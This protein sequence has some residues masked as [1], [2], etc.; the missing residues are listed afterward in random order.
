MAETREEAGAKAKDKPDKRSIDVVASGSTSD[1]PIESKR[2]KYLKSTTAKRIHEEGYYLD[3]EM[4][5]L[6][7]STDL[8]IRAALESVSFALIT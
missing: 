3:G 4:K 2:A 5:Y 7:P 8:L 6:Y 1:N